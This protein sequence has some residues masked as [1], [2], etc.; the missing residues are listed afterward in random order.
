MTKS[1]QAL[2]DYEQAQKSAADAYTQA[3]VDIF[4]TLGLDFKIGTNHWGDKEAD[5][6]GYRVIMYTFPRQFQ[7]C[8]LAVSTTTTG[9]NG[10]FSTQ[11]SDRIKCITEGGA[12]KFMRRLERGDFI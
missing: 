5:Y 7:G 8:K 6:H 11:Y 1:G 9:S 2:I 4:A 12:K 3:W 10:F